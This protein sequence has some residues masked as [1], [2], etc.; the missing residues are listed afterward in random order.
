M[1]HQWRCFLLCNIIK[2][3]LQVICSVCMDVC[4][5][6]LQDKFIT[7]TQL[8]FQKRAF[9]LRKTN[10]D[11]CHGHTRI[12]FVVNE[13]VECH[14]PVGDLILQTELH[15]ATELD[16]R[17]FICLCRDYYGGCRKTIDVIRRHHIVVGRDPFL[18]KSM[19]GGDPPGG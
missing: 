13:C 14:I 8:T 17:A 5:F 11:V 10:V 2:C 1:H 18:M 4:S 12:G 3:S 19:I 9:P 16:V 7:S 15:V 6:N